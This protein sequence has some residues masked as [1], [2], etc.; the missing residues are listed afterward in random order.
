MTYPDVATNYENSL[1][2]LS[3]GLEGACLCHGRAAVWRDTKDARE[4]VAGVAPRVAL[5]PLSGFIRHVR[6]ALPAGASAGLEPW[7]GMIDE[8]RVPLA[9]VDA[10]LHEVGQ[11]LATPALGLAALRHLARGDGDVVELGAECAA[12][13]GDAL[14]FFARHAS[15]LSDAASFHVHSNGRF[16][17]LALLTNAPVGRA[18]REYRAAALALG[19]RHWSGL[20]VGWA[21]WF[22]GPEPTYAAHYRSALPGIDVEFNAPFDALVL[23]AQRLEA[24]LP[25]SNPNLHAHLKR[26][27]ERLSAEYSAS[28]SIAGTVRNLLTELL[29]QGECTMEVV[30]QR[31]ALSP[32]TVARRLQQQGLE[33][34]T[35]LSEFRREKAMD[36]LER[37]DLSPYAI[38]QLLGYA[39]TSAFSRAFSRWLGQ[40]P[41]GYRRASRK[42]KGAGAQRVPKSDFVMREDAASREIVGRAEGAGAHR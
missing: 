32:R 35:V 16:A 9:A 29:P 5:Q 3:A 21:L 1:T 40:S 4:A 27:A 14:C 10:W 19:A 22:S 34:S 6:A 13:V 42:G 20:E 2:S 37:T 25:R 11:R 12:T 41:V 8:A 23:P 33:F 39:S 30:A 28:Y 36:Y 24:P 38:S 7:K 15:V 26:Y 18:L 31:L 17:V